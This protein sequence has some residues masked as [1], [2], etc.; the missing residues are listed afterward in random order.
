VIREFTKRFPD[1]ALL[2]WVRGRLAR[3]RGDRDGALRDWDRAI[4]AEGASAPSR[5][6]IA[7]AALLTELRR[8]DAAQ[9]AYHEITR[10]FPDAAA[11][12]AGLAEAAVQR[13]A[14]QEALQHFDAAVERAGTEAP[15]WWL[16]Q[17]INVLMRLRRLDEAESQAAA[18]SDRFP[19]SHL[20]FCAA[21]VVSG[22]RGKWSEAFQRWQQAFARFKSSMPPWTYAAYANAAIESGSSE[23]AVS[24][25][26]ALVERLS[27]DR[28]RIAALLNQVVAPAAKARARAA[29]YTGLL[30]QFP[31]LAG[32][33]TRPV[34]DTAK[35]EDHKAASGN[36]S[37]SRKK[38]MNPD[39]DIAPVFVLGTT[40]SGT[41]VV[42]LA[43]LNAL[44]YKGH[45]E[46]HLLPLL[47]DLAAAAEEFWRRSGPAIQASTAVSHV[48]RNA[49]LEGICNLVAGV[50]RSLYAGH[51][52]AEKTPSI[53]AI[54]AAPLIHRVWPHAKVIY[55]RR[56]G[57]E[58]VQS[59]RRKFPEAGFRQQCVEWSRCMLE[60][61]RVKADVRRHCEVDQFEIARAP[62]SSARRIGDVLGLGAEQ[63]SSIARFFAEE[64]PQQQSK[65]HDPVKLD[66]MTWTPEEKSLFRELC[67]PA[68]EAY[69]YTYDERY[70]ES[71]LPEDPAGE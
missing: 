62:V 30:K 68:M 24:V 19:E 53:Q 33:L 14:W 48:D 21:A 35:V 39:Q 3:H 20:G 41:S 38:D 51:P 5:W 54:W 15:A 47:H 60:W 57:I 2:F 61:R 59:K 71:A 4:Q 12:W 67:G 55:C 49:V 56:R 22:E 63:V 16:Y 27:G 45:G 25:C 8:T 70:W 44:G 29:L 23:V 65:T 37:A 9:S 36:S 26:A 50:Y 11:G 31:D 17:R 10:R 18:L 34:E 32:V 42:Q 43:L 46:G 13:N 66:D 7:R 69:G 64:A 52:F 28:T 40:R 1:D 58:N 6:L